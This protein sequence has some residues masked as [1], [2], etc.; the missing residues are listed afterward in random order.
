MHAAL[1]LVLVLSA[2]A[3]GLKNNLEMPGGLPPGTEPADEDTLEGR[4]PSR[5]PQ[6]L[7]Q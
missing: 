7:G 5:P 4:D 1:L 3:C 6:P 2:A